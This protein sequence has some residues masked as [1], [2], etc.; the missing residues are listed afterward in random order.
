MDATKSIRELH[1]DFMEAL[2]ALRASER[3]EYRGFTIEPS[4]GY[5]GG[6]SYYPT[7]EGRNE[8]A[9]WDGDSWRNCGNVQWAA[10]LDDAKDAIM[11]KYIESY[12]HHI[13][14]TNFGM[15]EYSFPWLVDAI[16]FQK[17]W[18]GDL[19]PC[20]QPIMNP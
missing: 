15:M 10:S 14:R 7:A 18:G 1:Q 20:G 5:M 2:E 13:V 6:Y 9:E 3:I 16:A 11:E 12:P 8:D 17:M 19:L 4:T